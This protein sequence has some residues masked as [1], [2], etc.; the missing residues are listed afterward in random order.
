MALGGRSATLEITDFCNEML[1]E[2]Y[3]LLANAEL[4]LLSITF[5]FFFVAVGGLIDSDYFPDLT[6]VA[7]E[8]F[9]LEL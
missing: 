8:I 1:L 4:L 9:V 5:F 2:F 7:I 3:V 6:V